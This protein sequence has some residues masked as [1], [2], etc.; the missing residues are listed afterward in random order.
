MRINEGTETVIELC[1]EE[2]VPILI[3]CSSAEVTMRPR[4]GPFPIAIGLSE[5]KAEPPYS[6]DDLPPYAASKLRAERLVL[7][8]NMTFL[9]NGNIDTVEVFSLNCYTHSLNLHGVSQ[10]YFSIK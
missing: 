1:K 10:L 3:H 7:A 5:Y 4:L 9:Q 8:E 6:P 2:N